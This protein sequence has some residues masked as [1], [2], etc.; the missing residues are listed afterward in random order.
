MGRSEKGELGGFSP[1]YGDDKG[2]K[3]L[4]TGERGEGGGVKGS[5]GDVT[6]EITTFNVGGAKESP[7][8]EH[9]VLDVSSRPSGKEGLTMRAAG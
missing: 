8:Q 9:R 3:N 6:C 1:E 2:R 7:R 4:Q 5:A